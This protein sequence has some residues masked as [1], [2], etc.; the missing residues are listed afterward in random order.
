[1][2]TPSEPRGEKRFRHL[3]TEADHEQGLPAGEGRAGD[4]PNERSD[5]P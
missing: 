2:T 4:Q 1:M 3:E 5:V